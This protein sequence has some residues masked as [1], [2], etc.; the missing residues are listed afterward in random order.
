MINTQRQPDLKP[1]DLVMTR[2]H[3]YCGRRTDWHRRLWNP[4]SVTVLR[5][6]LEAVDLLHSGYF[7]S[8]T[9]TGLV[10]TARRE[11][12][13]DR[14]LGSPAVRSAIT[15]ALDLLEKKP[16]NKIA[17]HQL[18][19]C[20]RNIEENYLK[21]WKNALVSSKSE[22]L[23]SEKA[24]R[25]LAGHL[26]GL[27][28]SPDRLHQ[29]VTWLMKREEPP[30]TLIELFDEAEKLTHKPPCDWQVLVPFIALEQHSQ[31]MPCK[32]LSPT[33][34]TKWLSKHPAGTT[35]RHN[36]GFL[37]SVEAR[38]PW[39][40][41][42]I[43]GDLIESIAARV[44]VGTPGISRFEPHTEAFVANVDS[45]LRL[46]RPR[47]QVDIHSLKRQNALFSTTESTL[48]GRIRTAIDLAA[49]FETG[50]P[51]TAVAGGWA[52]LE[53]VLARPE[54]ANVGV[55]ADL[56]VLVACSFPRAELTPLTY[57]YSDENNDQLSKDLKDASS[58]LERCELLGTAI[59]EGKP[60]LFHKPSDQAAGQR[61]RHILIKPN[62]VL[63]RVCAYVEEAMRRLYR[64]RNMV[65]HV[66]KTDS[67]AM[68]DVLRSAPPLVGAGLDRLV[69]DSLSKSLSD[70]LKLVANARTAL[71]M[72][73]KQGGPKPWSLL[74]D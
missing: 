17:R 41:V 39:S 24:S 40:A 7:G 37:L 18:E 64:Q 38:D 62:D 61:I 35:V 51:E 12:G 29:W 58:N 14:G 33:E 32:W 28:F 46:E 44:T 23:T 67:V 6:T 21:R 45:P 54:A 13:S 74:E 36:G 60:M 43:V 53:A 31:K 8:K 68:S 20:L 5:E 59:E 1:S 55:A 47:R 73:G 16:E 49:V 27:G 4:G 30:S 25:L 9:V 57:A 70:P 71:D 69:H 56:A 3:D 26:L 63:Q 15:T 19:Y 48:T 42:E 65:L 66:G 34:T 22:S 10:E 50:T 52:S 2:L 72:C 11:T